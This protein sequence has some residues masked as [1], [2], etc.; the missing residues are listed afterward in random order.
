[1]RVKYNAFENLL[2]FLAIL[3][4]YLIVYGISK[5]FLYI[6]LAI[7]SLLVCIDI[8]TKKM[9][10]IEMIKVIGL[11]IISLLFIVIYSDANFYISFMLALVCIKKDNENFIKSFF[12]SSVIMYLTTMFLYSF[13]LLKEHDLIRISDSGLISKRYSLGFSH[14]NEVFLFFLP[15]ALSGYFIYGKK[16]I[17]YIILLISSTILYKL[18]YC[19][20]GYILI[21]VLMILAFLFNRFYKKESIEKIAPYMIFICTIASIAIAVVYGNDLKN[22]VCKFLSG[23]PYYWN[24]YIERGKL[25]SIFGKNR[26]G[27]YNLDNFYIYMLVEL[28]ALGYVIYSYIYYTSLKLLKFD[29]RYVVILMIFFLYGIT[30]TNVIVGSIQFIFAIQL[31]VIIEHKGLLVKNKFKEKRDY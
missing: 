5:N 16:K 28:G 24:D 11:F 13:G 18:S 7:L 26:I 30:E 29:H 6:Y 15:I 23:R 1:M 9:K 14:P 8:Y 31:T 12:I 20:T 10:K 25:I 19:R 17:F 3:F 22:S 4:K 27:G 2:V 21:Y